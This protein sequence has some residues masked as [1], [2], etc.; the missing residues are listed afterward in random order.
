MARAKSV[1][2]PVRPPGAVPEALYGT[3]GDTQA[4]L[5]RRITDALLLAL[6]AGLHLALLLVIFPNTR[7]DSVLHGNLRLF[8]H[9][10]GWTL[11]GAVPYRDFLFEYPPGSLLFMLVPHVFSV[12]F[13]GYRTLFF[14]ESAVLDVI[15]VGALYALARGAGL[16]PLRVLVLYTLAVAALGPLVIYRIDLA[17]AALTMLALLAWQ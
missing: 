13:L 15:V 5:R 14:V 11:A 8:F 12:G 10:S 4:T 9:D 1:V 16:P 17:P 7:G 6:T 3:R 2:E